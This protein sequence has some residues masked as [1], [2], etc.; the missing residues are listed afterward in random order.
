MNNQSDKW[1][2]PGI[3]SGCYCLYDEACLDELCPHLQ[4]YERSEVTALDASAWQYFDAVTPVRAVIDHLMVDRVPCR[5]LRKL[6]TKS[7]HV[8]TDDFRQYPQ[9][10]DNNDRNDGWTDSS[11]KI[12]CS[13]CGSTTTLGT[14]MATKLRFA[15]TS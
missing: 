1:D 9:D 5:L 10:T 4:E 3:D 8:H 15:Y 13:L 7:V 12:S 6:S 14:E 11:P 2:V